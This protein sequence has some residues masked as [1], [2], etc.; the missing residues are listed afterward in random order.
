[1]FLKRNILPQI[2]NIIII[3]HG[4][5]LLWYGGVPEGG[6]LPADS[7]L[8]AVSLLYCVMEDFFYLLC[9]KYF[10]MDRDV[11]T[12][13]SPGLGPGFEVSEINSRITHQRLGS[14]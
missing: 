8:H 1:M 11:K 10:F 6:A 12:G 13:K 3:G 9:T 4:G 2:I 5:L 14:G 7:L